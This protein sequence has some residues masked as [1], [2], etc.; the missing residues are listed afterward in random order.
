VKPF[1]GLTNEAQVRVHRHAASDSY[2]G[3][4]DRTIRV[5]TLYFCFTRVT[6]A[7]SGLYYRGPNWASLFGLLLVF[8]QGSRSLNLSGVTRVSRLGWTILVCTQALLFPAEFAWADPFRVVAIGASNTSGWI[9]SSE[10]AYPQVL[11]QMLRTAGY[12]VR[13]TNS[14]RPFDTTAG[15][16]ARLDSAI[17]DRTDL[18]ILQPGGNDRRFFVSAERRANNITE[19][20]DHLRSRRIAVI[21]FD[22]VF[23][24][25]YYSF[26]RIHF[27]PEAHAKIAAELMSRVITKIQAK[28]T[29]AKG[30]RPS[31]GPAK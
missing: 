13:V 21:V 26:D 16:L 3:G 9:V 30:G 25:D 4:K 29:S 22:P 18:V 7:G 19:I 23:P 8:S 20:T 6:S 14:G 10:Q 17:P 27:T 15:M 11:E 24:D 12:D 31:P 1:Q 5:M 2:G 28:Q